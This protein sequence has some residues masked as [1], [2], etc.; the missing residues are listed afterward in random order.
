MMK[1]NKF[2]IDKADLLI[3]V[4]NDLGGGTGATIKYAKSKGVEVVIIQP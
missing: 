2:M 4:C 3:A 1:R